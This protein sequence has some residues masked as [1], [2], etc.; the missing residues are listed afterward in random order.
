MC[1]GC[2]AC[3]TRCEFDAISLV[4]THNE[5]GVDFPDLKKAVVKHALKRKVRIT[6]RKVKNKFTRSDKDA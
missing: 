1:V 5:T 2:G 6:A 4:K 3:T